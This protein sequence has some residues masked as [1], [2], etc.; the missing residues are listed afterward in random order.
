MIITRKHAQRLVREGKA[1]I[2]DCLTV[3]GGRRY[4]LVTRHDKQR[5]DHVAMPTT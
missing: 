4:Q 1:T 3:D 2:E 5:M